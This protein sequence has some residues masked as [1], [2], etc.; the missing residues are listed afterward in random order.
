MLTATFCRLSERFV[1]VTMISAG[2]E[3]SSAGGASWDNA[4][5]ANIVEAKR[6][7]VARYTAERRGYEFDFMIVLDRLF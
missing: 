6:A 5:V 4:G 7:S 3:S 2:R 1:A